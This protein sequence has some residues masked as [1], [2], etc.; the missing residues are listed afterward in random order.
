VTLRDIQTLPCDLDLLHERHGQQLEAIFDELMEDYRNNS[1]VRERRDG[2]QLQV[3]YPSLSK[4]IMDRI[5]RILA[6]YYR[7]TDEE[8]DFILNYDIKYRMGDA[9]F[10]NEKEDE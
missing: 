8:L 3:F 9:L 7:F 2:V 1:G 4:P 10:E 5:D 6:Q